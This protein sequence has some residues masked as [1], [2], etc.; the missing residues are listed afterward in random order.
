MALLHRVQPKFQELPPTSTPSRGSTPSAPG[1]RPGRPGSY[2]HS[3]KQTC[4]SELPTCAPTVAR[5][6]EATLSQWLTCL[7]YTSPSPR[8]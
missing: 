5:L 3:P 2:R 8:D 6:A 1:P 7:L 4:S